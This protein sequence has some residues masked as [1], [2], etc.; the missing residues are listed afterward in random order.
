M[1]IRNLQLLQNLEKDHSLLEGSWISV[2]FLFCFYFLSFHLLPSYDRT[3]SLLQLVLLLLLVPPCLQ[4]AVF[5]CPPLC[6]SSIPMCV[7]HCPACPLAPINPKTHLGSHWFN[8]NPRRRK[9]LPLPLPLQDWQPLPIQ[10][11]CLLSKGRVPDLAHLLSHPI[12][13]RM[14]MKVMR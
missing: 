5:C 7:S 2:K 12:H 3:P 6:D 9:L 1:N 11:L 8:Q 13:L 4:L 10:A 14:T